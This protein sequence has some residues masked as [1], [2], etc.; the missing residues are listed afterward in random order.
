[1]AVHLDESAT[2]EQRG[3]RLAVEA[4]EQEHLGC[5]VDGQQRRRPVAE[6]RDPAA[7]RGDLAV[8]LGP[9]AVRLA[10]DPP[11]VAERQLQHHR[12]AVRPRPVG[13]DLGAAEQTAGGRDDGSR[14]RVPHGYE[15][16]RSARVR[17]GGRR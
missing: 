5:V 15:C 9:L 8:E 6:H 2:A 3:R 14:P 1:M 16:A 13:D 10:D 12:L 11:T 17:T 7:V 4:A